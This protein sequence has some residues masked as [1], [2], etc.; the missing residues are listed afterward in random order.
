M[1]IDALIKIHIHGKSNRTYRSND[2]DRWAESYTEKH[3]IIENE[4]PTSTTNSNTVKVIAI[5]TNK[6]KMT[7]WPRGVCDIL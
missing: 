6:S 4:L 1:F 7:F 5:S 2:Q 3:T